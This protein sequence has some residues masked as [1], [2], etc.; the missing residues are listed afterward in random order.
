MEQFSFQVELSPF[1]LVA[2]LNADA[3]KTTALNWGCTDYSA[4]F[5]KVASNSA[6]AGSRGRKV[7]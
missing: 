7:L 1:P 4:K 3:V 6:K 5:P 2:D